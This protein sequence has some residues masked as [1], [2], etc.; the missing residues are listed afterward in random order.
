MTDDKAH[1]WLEPYLEQ[2][3]VMGAPVTWLHDLPGFWAQF[4]VH[5]NVANKTENFRAKFTALK[6]TNSVQEYFKDFQTYSQGLGYNDQSLHDSFY[7]GLSVRIKEILM[8]QN[9]NHLAPTVTLQLLA[10][11]A[12]QIDQHLEAFQVQNK[13]AYSQATSTC[14][15]N[16]SLPLTASPGIAR[17]KMSFGEKVYMLGSD[18]KTCKGTVQTIGKHD[19]G[20][21]IPTVKWSDG[22]RSKAAF[23]QLKKDSYPGGATA[24]TV[25]VA[26]AAPSFQA[27]GP[28]I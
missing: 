13:G 22:S 4:N 23:K 14:S 2:D 1:E 28:M 27:P 26:T 16:T 15:K 5:W 7:D 3:V 12:L 9:Y 24:P 21:K 17:D 8:T 20:A 11:K 10:D 25:V 19:K 6:Q 18:G